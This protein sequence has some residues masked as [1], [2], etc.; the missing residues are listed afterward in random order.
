MLS[1]PSITLMVYIH[2]LCIEKKSRGGRK[3]QDGSVGKVHRHRISPIGVCQSLDQ[4]LTH[5]C[6]VFYMVLASTPGLYSQDPSNI[7]TPSCLHAA[8]C[9]LML[10]EKH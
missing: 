4:A 3:Q 2:Q 5:D 9:P 7:F 1:L 10:V 8:K 6:Y